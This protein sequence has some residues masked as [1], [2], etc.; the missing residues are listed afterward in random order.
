MGFISYMHGRNAT[1]GLKKVMD[2]T[3]WN[4][5]LPSLNSSYNL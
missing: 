2:Y 5:K 3:G 1:A 4:G